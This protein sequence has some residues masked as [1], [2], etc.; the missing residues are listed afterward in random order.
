M[1]NR[2]QQ[3]EL[4]AIIAYSLEE[5]LEK[6]DIDD[7]L[8][9]EAIEAI[10]NP[11]AVIPEP[12]NGRLKA[13]DI[14]EEIETLHRCIIH[15]YPQNRANNDAYVY[16][17]QDPNYVR[18]K[19]S[20]GLA[21][22]ERKGLLSL[23]NK[24]TPNDLFGGV[25]KADV[26]NHIRLRANEAIAKIRGGVKAEVSERD[27]Q[28]AQENAKLKG[29]AESASVPFTPALQQKILP[30]L[31]PLMLAEK[32]PMAQLAK[33]ELMDVIRYYR[34]LALLFEKNI[35]KFEDFLN[36]PENNK[37]IFIAAFNH[38]SKEENYPFLQA[39]IKELQTKNA[40]AA[41]LFLNDQARNNNP[42][43]LLTDIQAIHARF[44][45]I[46]LFL[47]TEAEKQQAKEA[48]M[49]AQIPAPLVKLMQA[50]KIPKIFLLQK[51]RNKDAPKNIDILKSMYL[52]L[53]DSLD[54]DII[55]FEDLQAL[56]KESQQILTQILQYK[57]TGIT[58]PFVTSLLAQLR[59]LSPEA[60]KQLLGAL[61]EGGYAL[62]E[63]AAQLNENTVD[64]FILLA[65][66][67]SKLSVAK[68]LALLPVTAVITAEQ[69]L[70][71]TAQ[72]NSILVKFIEGGAYASNVDGNFIKDL[73]NS[74]F[75]ADPA[76][77]EKLSDR[78]S[79]LEI[80]NLPALVAQAKT[81]GNENIVLAVNNQLTQ[82]IATDLKEF[83]QYVVDQ[84]T[85]F[86]KGEKYGDKGLSELDK[87]VPSLMA[88]YDEPYGSP[89]SQNI[90]FQ[91]SLVQEI[92]R[93]AT[94]EVSS[95]ALYRSQNYA[96]LIPKPPAASDERKRV[97]RKF[98]AEKIHLNNPADFAF[99]DKIFP[100]EG[101]AIR[102]EAIEEQ[103]RTAR[104]NVNYI[105]VQ[106][107]FLKYIEQASPDRISSHVD[108]TVFASTEPYMED[109]PMTF[110][111]NERMLKH[112]TLDEG[113]K[114]FFRNPAA[115]QTLLTKE[116]LVK[117]SNPQIF[118]LFEYIE[119]N[120]KEA[121]KAQPR[122]EANQQFMGG[123]RS[124]T[125]RW[126]EV[127]ETMKDCVFKNALKIDPNAQ[128]TQTK[129]GN[130]LKL[131]QD[132]AAK[133]LLGTDAAERSTLFRQ[134][135]SAT[136]LTT[137]AADQSP[138]MT[139]K[140]EAYATERAN[141]IQPPGHT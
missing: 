75:N 85:D 16:E 18:Y 84:A 43:D 136:L 91:S 140:V 65:S 27:Q 40:Y 139:T 96:S 33:I 111:L 95:A 6:E 46:N 131:A 59:G 61:S 69:C 8:K 34:P 99:V 52:P 81:S 92:K 97:I 57:T 70:A 101:A 74:I 68:V 51:E 5:V 29:L 82:D 58:G 89:R 67:T 141:R 134:P 88:L 109:P 35:I 13:A 73:Y 54:K 86:F 39:L 78:L 108:N 90:Y 123:M 122:L 41:Q 79:H 28:I 138:A 135:K 26:V 4:D 104:G 93:I 21:V 137:Y 129:G 128:Q 113:F 19:N 76:L 112:M 114:Q 125:S 110:L 132:P 77:L 98:I 23:T 12:L 3:V 83:E 126:S 25:T 105:S 120:N 37:K 15:E 64:M 94:S 87:T 107:F 63:N 32:I 11:N 10:F 47:A 17:S 117:L 1:L 121:L 45:Q 24:N 100:G 30:E 60:S 106:L 124:G 9:I 22:T 130:L 38:N 14:Y 66:S 31:R 72:Q 116:A 71:L 20:L 50:G 62:R 103:L 102:A 127:V 48:V 53:V 119:A 42:T 44:E 56:S 49:L 2:E 36:L 118:A 133:K 7:A 80:E 55:K 115:V